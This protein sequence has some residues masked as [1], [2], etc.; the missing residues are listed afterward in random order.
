MNYVISDIHGCKQ[1]FDAMLKKINYTQEDTLYIL[2]DIIDRGKDG[3]AL[4]KELMFMDNVI[5]ILGNHELYAYTLLEKLY[6]I[7]EEYRSDLMDPSFLKELEYWMMDGGDVTIESFKKLDKESKCMIIEY[8]KEFLLWDIVETKNTT[9][10]LVHAGLSNFSPERSLDS[11]TPEELVYERFD[12]EQPF[13]PEWTIISGH[14]P[15]MLLQPERP[16][17]IFKYKNHRVIDCGCVFGGR[18]ACLCLDTMEE[19]YVDSMQGK[20]FEEIL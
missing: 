19:Y 10:L 2:G 13:F 11:Y 15:T 1:E 16:A 18:L 20:N 4:L 14:T 8:L 12:Y 7:E 3:I 17:K 6:L 5:P 9:F